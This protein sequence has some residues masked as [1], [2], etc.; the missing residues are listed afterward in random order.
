LQSQKTH[1]LAKPY[2]FTHIQLHIAIVKR[3]CNVHLIVILLLNGAGSK[4]VAGSAVLVRTVLERQLAEGSNHVLN[5]RVLPVAVLAAEGVEPWNLVEEVVDDGDDNGDTNGVSPDDNDGDNVDPSVITELAVDRRGVGLVWLTRHP[6]EDSEDGGK[7]VDT[8]NGDDKLERGESLAT[9]GNEDQPVLSKRDL[10]EQD[11]LDSTE[12]LDD[13]TVVEEESA[14]D[15]PGTESEQET[16]NDRDEP[17]LGQLPLNGA[18]VGVSVVVSDGDGSQISE[19]GEEDNKLGTDGLVED[20]HRGDEVDLQVQAKSDTVLDVGLHALED[21]AGS[22][23]GKDDGGQTGGK[24]DDIS[25]SLGSLGGTLDGNTTVR[26]LERWGV[27]D[28]VTSHSSQMTTLL[29]HLDDLVLVFGEDFGET[30]GT[31]DEIVLGGTGETAVD[32]LGR[33]VDLGSESKHLAGL[34]GDGNSVTTV[35]C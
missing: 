16:E 22:L 6:S 30:V 17:N 13:T 24:E 12:V 21:L 18:G 25:G 14:T 1:G 4:N 31:L 33:V 10:E 29:Q 9:T 32:E 35:D 11:G 5:S 20:D 27:V 19:Q 15:D 23:D 3:S 8:E 28:T 2:S 26:L 7:S 34:L